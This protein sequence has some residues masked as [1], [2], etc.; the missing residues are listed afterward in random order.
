MT[1]LVGDVGG[2]RPRA[3]RLRRPAGGRGDGG[4]VLRRHGRCRLVARIC[5]RIRGLVVAG[6][7]LGCGLLAGCGVVQ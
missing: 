5:G 2:A 6:T 4:R 1:P 7:V 3:R